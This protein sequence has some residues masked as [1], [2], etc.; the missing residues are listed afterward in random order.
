MARSIDAR[1]LAFGKYSA[2]IYFAHGHWC[3][4]VPGF[5]GRS[6]FRLNSTTAAEAERELV[7]ILL[8]NAGIAKDEIELKL[9]ER[10]DWIDA[11]IIVSDKTSC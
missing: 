5:P 6:P 10:Y 4:F 3:A 7:T 11:R 9:R 8:R 2:T 1:K